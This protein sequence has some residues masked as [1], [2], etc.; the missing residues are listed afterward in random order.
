MRKTLLYAFLTALA[1]VQLFP[2][3]W[4]LDYSLVKSG[5]LFGPE[6]LRW[7]NPFQWI[8]YVRAWVDGRIPLYLWNSTVVVVG[9]VAA[10]TLFSFMISYACTRM[11]WRLRGLVYGVVM[12]GMVVPL[13]TTLLPNFI[14]FNVFGLINRQ[15]GLIIP[16]VA[17][18]LSFNTLIFSGMLVNLPRSVE[19]SAWLEGAGIGRLLASIVA[20]MVLPA[21]ATTVIMTFLN[22]WNEFIMAYTFISSDRLRTLPFAIIRFQGQYSSAYAIQFACLMIVAIIPIILYYTFNKWIIAGATA[23]AV[24]G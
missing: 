14:W 20:P 5:E 13:H 1:V 8:N 3:L 11:K 15:V 18:T 16:Y 2:L 9:S 24:K 19:E 4:L 17:F 21:F 23:G 12:L 7:P 22:N 6:I 10:S